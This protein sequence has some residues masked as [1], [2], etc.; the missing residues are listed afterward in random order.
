MVS[1]LQVGTNAW[2]EFYR[3]SNSETAK[4][5]TK[6]RATAHTK[7]GKRLNQVSTCGYRKEKKNVQDIEESE[8]VKF[9]G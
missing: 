6:T 2:D 9:N 3:M 4:D 1:S 8:Q 5:R 7:L